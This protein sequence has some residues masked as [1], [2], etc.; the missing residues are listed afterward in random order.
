[1]KHWTATVTKQHM[2]ANT[3]Y[4]VGREMFHRI[5]ALQEQAWHAI[6]H[7]AETTNYCLFV[8]KSSKSCLVFNIWSQD[9]GLG[10]K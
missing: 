2:S 4:S 7:I 8:S 1:M 3:Y 6:E 9:F 10:K 5:C